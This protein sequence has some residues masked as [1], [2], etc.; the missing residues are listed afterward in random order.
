MRN[1]A[2]HFGYHARMS[3]TIAVNADELRNAFEFVSLPSSMVPTFA[4]IRPKLLPIEHGRFRRRT[5]H[6]RRPRNLRPLHRRAAQERPRS[7]LSTTISRPTS[8]RSPASSADAAPMGI[9]SSFLPRAAP[10]N[11]GTTSKNA[12]PKKRSMPGART[13][14]SS[15]SSN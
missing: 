7:P 10:C 9:S 14:A 12:L 1:A 8:K 2:R 6:S 11:A 15:P 4:A 13:M 5:R 3:K